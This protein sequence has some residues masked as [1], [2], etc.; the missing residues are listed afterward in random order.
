MASAWQSKAPYP[1]SQYNHGANPADT[2]FSKIQVS[3]RLSWE[4]NAATTMSAQ[5]SHVL[6]ASVH[7]SQRGMQE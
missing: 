7:P 6:A 2:Y 1:G 5:A 3:G 4:V